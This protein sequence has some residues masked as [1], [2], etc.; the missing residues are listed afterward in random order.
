MSRRKKKGHSPD[1]QP[2][3]GKT[4]TPNTVAQKMERAM[5]G[6][7]QRAITERERQLKEADY[8]K[9]LEYVRGNPAI[10]MKEVYDAVPES[11]R[12][13]ETPPGYRYLRVP[14][15]PNRP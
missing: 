14:Q 5:I 8:N 6:A 10:P 15:R 7:S 9:Y 1:T 13:R 4:Q 3:W 11:N 12:R 2:W